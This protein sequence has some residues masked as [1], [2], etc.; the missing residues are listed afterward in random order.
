MNE[1]VLYFT[2][3]ALITSAFSAL[4]LSFKKETSNVL[5]GEGLMAV[6]I[7]TFLVILSKF[8]GIIYLETVALLIL[9]CGPVG[10]IA[11]SKFMRK[12]D[13]K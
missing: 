3:F 8:Y 1:Y 2:M 7:A 11:F 9:V 6:V 12:I 10:T 4:R 5:I 13:I